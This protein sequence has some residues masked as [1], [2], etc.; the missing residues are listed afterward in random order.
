MKN[1]NLEILK[2]MASKKLINQKPLFV[3]K[4]WDTTDFSVL[5]DE[6]RM[7]DDSLVECIWFANEELIIPIFNALLHQYEGYTYSITNLL[8]DQV[9]ISGTMDPSD[10]YA[11]GEYFI[12]NEE[13]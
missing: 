6:T 13:E 10:N 8:S 11:L 4:I 2:Q 7:F 3:I 12:D 5:T 1:D 9:I